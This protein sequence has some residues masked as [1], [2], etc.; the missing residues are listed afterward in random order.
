MHIHMFISHPKLFIIAKKLQ[1]TK[2]PTMYVLLNRFHHLD[3][4]FSGTKEY[5]CKIIFS[6]I[7]IKSILIQLKK[8]NK[9]ACLPQ[10]CQLCPESMNIYLLI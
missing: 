3:G 7:H 2:C 5:V 9:N 4:F 6:R 8:Q 1:K 10:H